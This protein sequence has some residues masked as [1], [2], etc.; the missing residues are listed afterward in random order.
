MPPADRTRLKDRHHIENVFCRL[1]QFR[2]LK[3]RVDRNISSFAACHAVA[4]MMMTLSSLRKGSAEPKI[5]LH[6]RTLVVSP[7]P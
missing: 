2:S 3:Y 1:D 5:Q 7:D 6:T 4:M